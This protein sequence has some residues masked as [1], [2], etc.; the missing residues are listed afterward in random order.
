MR[1][2]PRILAGLSPYFSFPSCKFRVEAEK[3]GTG[4]IV[5]WREFNITNSFTL[6]CSAYCFKEKS[7]LV[8]FTQKCFYPSHLHE[9]GVVVLLGMHDYHFAL[10][11]LELELKI[12]GGWL[13]PNRMKELSGTPA[14]MKPVDARQ[15]R[16]FQSIRPPKLNKWREFFEEGEL[17]K[18][19]LKPEDSESSGSDS[20]PSEDNLED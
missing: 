18:I 12:N 20:S 4:R 8:C 6:E 5:V 7:K 2:Y 10:K 11:S 9:L 15:E 14:L 1:L 16:L 19:Y 17:E 3:L 13:K